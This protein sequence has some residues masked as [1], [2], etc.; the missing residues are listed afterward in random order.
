MDNPE[1]LSSLGTQDTGR[2]QT[3]QKHNKHKKL[4]KRTTWVKLF[5]LRRWLVLI[6]EYLVQI[7]KKWLPDP[8]SLFISGRESVIGY[9]DNCLVYIYLISFLDLN[10]SKCLMIL[11]KHHRHPN[12]HVFFFLLLIF[13]FSALSFICWNMET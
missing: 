6:S 2:R 5:M 3:N 4:I 1:T 13:L 11:T 10:W 9:V 8:S 12:T 7:K